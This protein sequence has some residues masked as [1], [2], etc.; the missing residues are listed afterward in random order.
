MR[1]LFTYSNLQ[2]KILL[3]DDVSSFFSYSTN[4]TSKWLQSL[5]YQSALPNIWPCPCRLLLPRSKSPSEWY[6]F[7]REYIPQALTWH[8]THLTPVQK[9]VR[10]PLTIR[11][12]QVEK[13]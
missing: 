10:H 1:K 4:S 13:K 5:I 8:Q 9:Q 2:H 3:S 6:L 7:G 12:K 11:A